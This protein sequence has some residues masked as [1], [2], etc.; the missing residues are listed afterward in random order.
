MHH[1]WRC[2]LDPC[3]SIVMIDAGVSERDNT[4]PRYL[5]EA[6]LYGL[7]ENFLLISVATFLMMKRRRSTIVQAA[8]GLLIE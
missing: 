5:H 6:A 4:A 1:A 2:C 8:P 3:G 7:T